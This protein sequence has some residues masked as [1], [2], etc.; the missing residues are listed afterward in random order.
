MT[1]TSS[2]L[3]AW[4]C[5]SSPL[6]QGLTTKPSRCSSAVDEIESKPLENVDAERVQRVQLATRQ[7]YD[8]QTRWPLTGIA[9]RISQTM[10]L[11]RERSV[12]LLP[13]FEWEMRRGLWWQALLIDSRAAQLCGV[14]MNAYSYSFWDTESPR[15][16]PVAVNAGVRDRPGATEMLFCE[17]RFEIGDCM[18]KLTAM[19][20]QPVVGTMAEKMIAEDLTRRHLPK[21]L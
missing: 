1:G 12:T 20:H 18:R 10:G 16:R 11:H 5:C 13:V 19:E 14:A 4:F 17:I 21:G 2:D 6:W 7:K 3:V 9:S 15:N 8:T